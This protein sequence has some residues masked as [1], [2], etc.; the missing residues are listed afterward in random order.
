[1]SCSRGRSRKSSTDA[2]GRGHSRRS[3]SKLYVDDIDS[4]SDITAH[5]DG[6][7]DGASAEGD[8]KDGKTVGTAA[9]FQRSLSSG[10]GGDDDQSRISKS[11]SVPP[12]FTLTFPPLDPQQQRANTV[13]TFGNST[14]QPQQLHQGSSSPPSNNGIH[15]V[16][17]PA[18]ASNSVVTGF[19]AEVDE[20]YDA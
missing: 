18:T 9:V 7:D 20:D 13:W 15:S 4:E 14:S 1:M 2:S 19:Y 5:S 10:L 3:S 6:N 8:D 12:A 17:S 11:N 16:S